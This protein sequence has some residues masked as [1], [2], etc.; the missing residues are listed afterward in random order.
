M[1]KG[2]QYNGLAKDEGNITLPNESPELTNCFASSY[3][4]IDDFNT[5]AFNIKTFFADAGTI[6][7]FDV[8]AMD[9]LHI[10]ADF[11]VEWEMCDVAAIFGQ[12]KGM[13]G[14][15]WAA[16]ADN[17]SREV[18]VIVLEMPDGFALMSQIAE[19]SAC[20]A[21]AVADATGGDG[22]GSEGSS[23]EKGDDPAF[24]DAFNSDALD[25]AAEAAAAAADCFKNVDRWS[26]GEISGKLFAKFFDNELKTNV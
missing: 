7:I 24:W 8:M 2:F 19:A 26:I 22:E 11:T 21:T 6:K 12:F 5:L 10:F 9:P 23:T 3:A 13:I 15:D 16:I 25:N 4:L 18:L 20:A 1:V 17:L 14:G